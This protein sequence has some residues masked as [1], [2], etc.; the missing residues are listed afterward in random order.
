MKQEE[1]GREV[2]KTNKECVTK[3]VAAV[4]TGPSGMPGTL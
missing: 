4:G 3:L 2:E 1:R